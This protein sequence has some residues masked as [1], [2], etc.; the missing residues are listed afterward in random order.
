MPE[1]DNLYPRNKTLLVIPSLR[2]KGREKKEKGFF[3]NPIND[4]LGAPEPTR[5][6][7][8]QLR[9]LLLYPAELRAQAN[10]NIHFFFLV[11]KTFRYK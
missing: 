1:T 4:A 11:R 2:S 5:T 9:R 8:P 7:D 6:A 10:N 3:R